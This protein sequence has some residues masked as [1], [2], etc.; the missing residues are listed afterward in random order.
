MNRAVKGG[1]LLLLCLALWGCSQTYPADR[2]KESIQ[3]ICRRE[4]GVENIDVKISG[5]TIGVYLPIRK[6][7]VTD[8]KDALSRKNIKLTDIENLFRPSPE[9]LE[10]VE[11]VLFSISR[12]LLST[13]RELDFYTLQA[14]DVEQTG[15]Q[16]I[17]TGYVNDIKR[18]RL[19]DISRDEYRKRVLHEIHLNRASVWHRPVRAFFSDLE[20]SPSLETAKSHFDGRIT[21]ELFESLFFLEPERNANPPASWRLGELRSTPLEAT[22]VLVHVPV[23]VEYPSDAPGSSRIFQI[24]SGSLL[25]YFFV[26]SFVNERPSILR[27]IPLFHVNESGTVQKMSVPEELHLEKDIQ[28]WESE[29]TVPDIRAGDFLAEQLTRRAQS[30][31]SMDERVQNTFETLHFTFRYHQEESKN[32]FSAEIDARLKSRTSWGSAPTALDEDMLHVLNLAS[33][34]FVEVLRSYQFLDYEFL[35]LNLASD[36]VSH[37]LGREELELFRRNKIDLQGLLGGISPF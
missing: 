8:L 10:Q 34:E 26:V 18:V 2:I 31:L 32:Y 4:Y 24:R 16:L 30:L 15:L 25:E 28:S 14:T 9:A 17:L 11:D 21:P 36:P 6:L 35:Q 33:R 22:Q 3:E 27:V 5:K 13:D 20:K 12:V 19:W 29:F 23:R 1:N 37:V 7:F